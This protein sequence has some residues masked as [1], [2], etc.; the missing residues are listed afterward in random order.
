[1]VHCKCGNSFNSEFSLDLH[2][3]KCDSWRPLGIPDPEGFQTCKKCTFRKSFEEFDDH[4]NRK[5]GKSSKCKECT[6]SKNKD[7]R[8]SH[9][10]EIIRKSRE[11]YYDPDIHSRI[12]IEKKEYH[13]ENKE[14]ISEKKKNYRVKNL[15]KISKRISEWREKNVEYQFDK[16]KSYRDRIKNKLF[17]ILGHSC[18]LC[19]ETSK[20]KLTVDHINGDGNADRKYGS[21]GW[22]RKI[23]KGERD[24]KNYRILCH[25]C[26]HGSY[27]KNPHHHIRNIPKIGVMKKCPTCCLDKDISFFHSHKKKY[28]EI[29]FECR[30][31]KKFRN[32]V[33]KNECFIKFGGKCI[34]CG[35]KEYEKLCIDHKSDSG[36]RRR[37]KDSTGIDLYRKILNSS[38]DSSDFQLL[39]YNCNFLKSKRKLSVPSSD[40]IEYRIQDIKIKIIPNGSSFS[41]LNKYHYGGFGRGSSFEYG[42][43]LNDIMIGVCKFST[44]VRPGVA[45]SLGYA[46]SDVIEL[47]RLCLHPSYHKKNALSFCLSRIIRDVRNN[48]TY[49]AIAS[50]SDPSRG[51]SGSVYRA[52]NFSYLGRTSMSYFYIDSNENEVN[53]KSAF[54]YAKRLGMKES[55]YVSQN[56][57]VKVRLP[58]KHKFL[59]RLRLESFSSFLVSRF[60][61]I[62]MHEEF[63]ISIN[64]NHS[65][66]ENQIF[67]QDN[68]TI[69]IS[70]IEY[71]MSRFDVR[72]S[73]FVRIFH[74]KYGELNVGSGCYSYSQAISNFRMF[75]YINLP[76]FYESDFYKKNVIPHF[77]VNS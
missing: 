52:S 9:R 2:R 34:S 22:K 14:I 20:D 41:F 55:E 61:S 64:A 59:Y 53:K 49:K 46:Q 25:S 18:S 48:T 44:V 15:D 66:L 23:I 10:E 8:S 40:L 31:C 11:R 58:S 17:D 42:F 13:K 29:Y 1:V 27:G 28:S 60:V 37:D 4:P 50:F 77:V 57:L 32:F 3:E 26:N 35:E 69:I 7:Y 45:T 56:S 54:D 67:N 21:L 62:Y 36:W 74:D 19:S 5:C 6:K 73:P 63:M 76:G 43:F 16:R 70:V 71:H 72:K 33:I 47:D 24:P 38:L 68:N 51:H 39:C 30:L 65:F 12:L 75:R